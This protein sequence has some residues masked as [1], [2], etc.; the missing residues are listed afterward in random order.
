MNQYIDTYTKSGRNM[1]KLTLGSAVQMDAHKHLYEKYGFAKAKSNYEYTLDLDEILDE[2]V[3]LILATDS[4]ASMVNGLKEIQ[5][6][7]RALDDEY[8]EKFNKLQEE[9]KRLKK[10]LNEKAS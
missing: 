10:E 7:A 5:K 3:K 2:S 1:L 4:I 6:R 8:K 9:N